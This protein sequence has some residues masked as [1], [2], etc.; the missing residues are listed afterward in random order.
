MESENNDKNIID[1]ALKILNVAYI[2]HNYFNH[3]T[4]SKVIL[5][6][7]KYLIKQSNVPALK[8]E[9]QF[10]ELNQDDILQQIIYVD[11]HYEFVIYKF[12]PGNVMKRVDDIQDF[13]HNI[14]SVT[15]NYKTYSSKYF[16]YLNE[17]VSSWSEFLKSEIDYALKN[18]KSYENY[19]N[20]I[21]VNILYDYAKKLDKYPFEK[22]LLHGDFGC[23]NFI[24]FNNKFAGIID[25]MPVIGDYLYDLLYAIVS[26]V[27]VVSSITFEDIIK[28]VNEP[29]EKVFYLLLIV[30]YCRIYRCLKYNS[31]YIDVYINFWNNLLQGG[32]I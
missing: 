3:G 18:L 5:L 14:V 22:K 24:K 23:H 8:A 16:G 10:L 2:S 26:N 25:P 20:I 27:Q 7:D 32:H 13:L 15:K 21:D 28:L 30:L 4:Y 11:P 12:I 6:N 19:S 17:E 9:I 29:K 31:A 1:K